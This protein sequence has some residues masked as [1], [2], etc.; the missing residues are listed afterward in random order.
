MEAAENN[1]LD[2]VKY[3]IKA[4]A[5]VDPKV[6][7]AHTPLPVAL[8]VRRS[9]AASLGRLQGLAATGHPRVLEVGSAACLAAAH[10]WEVL[11]VLALWVPSRTQT[12]AREASCAEGPAPPFVVSTS[13]LP[14]A[15]QSPYSRKLASCTVPGWTKHRLESRLP[16]QISTTSS[17]ADD[18]TVRAE[19]EKELN[20]LLMRVKAES[21]KAGLKLNVKKTEITSRGPITAWQIE[22]EKVEAVADLLFLGSKTTVVGD[23]S[24]EIRRGLLLGRK[25]VTCCCC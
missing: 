13:P 20:S 1:H 9:R 23:C 8:L 15:V 22:G 5:L 19:S 10:S 7:G 25:A 6:L 17:Y 12:S 16:G 11:W 3:L 21:E 4:G 2:A 24:L 14:C 18:T